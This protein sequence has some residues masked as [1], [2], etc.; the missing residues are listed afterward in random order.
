MR[1]TCLR[2]VPFEDPGAVAASLVK[3]GVGL[4]RYCV[5]RDGLQ[6]DGGDL[7][8]AMGGV[9]ALRQLGNL[10]ILAD[11][12]GKVIADFSM[13]WDCGACV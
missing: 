9:V 8:I 10:Q 7:S 3:R 12:S 13:P 2:H 1:T 6:K 11:F 4:E 5:P